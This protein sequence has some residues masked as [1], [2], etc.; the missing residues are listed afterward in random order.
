[1]IVA[2]SGISSPKDPTLD[3]MDHVWQSVE[4]GTFHSLEE[5]GEFLMMGGAGCTPSQFGCND[6]HGSP[7]PVGS[8]R[9]GSGTGDPL[10]ATVGSPR[11]CAIDFFDP[12]GLCG[13]APETLRCRNTA[14]PT[15][16]SRSPS[17]RSSSPTLDELAALNFNSPSDGKGKGKGKGPGGFEDLVGGDWMMG[18]VFMP[19]GGDLV[20]S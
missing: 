10:A 9:R 20:Q 16:C 14:V 12:I 2:N 8:A 15:R 13:G 11:S 6:A 18:M 4:Q 5:M 1:L 7:S 17:A 19:S 3:E